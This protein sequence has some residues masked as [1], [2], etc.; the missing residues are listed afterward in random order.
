M[1]SSLQLSL[2]EVSFVEIPFSFPTSR[3][4]SGDFGSRR[5]LQQIFK[6]KWDPIS[7]PRKT[8]ITRLRRGGALGG[9]GPPTRPR[10]AR[11]PPLSPS[12]C[13]LQP[14]MRAPLSAASTGRA[15]TATRPPP[16]P[17]SVRRR[18]PRTPLALPPW[19]P[20]DSNEGQSEEELLKKGNI[21]FTS[22]SEKRK[23]WCE[24]FTSG[25]R[26]QV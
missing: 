2:F 6:E 17:R 9:P 13:V 15:P 26:M 11:G 10:A 18:R 20:S 4:R 14:L 5:D 24:S 3:P 19:K 22:C 8:T 1:E 25:D 7:C 12:A 21:W 16:P 23:K